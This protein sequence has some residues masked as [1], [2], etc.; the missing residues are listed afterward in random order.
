M[1]TRLLAWWD[2]IRSSYW[3]IPTGMAVGASILAWLVLFLEPSET[4]DFLRRVPWFYANQPAGARSLLSTIAGSM[5]TVAGVTFTVTIAAVSFTAGQFGP[6]ILT[7][8]MRDRGNQ[9]TLGTFIA[10]F[11]YGLLLLRTVREPGEPVEDPGAEGLAVVAEAFVPHVGIVVALMLAVLSVAVLIYFLHHVPESIHISNV[12]ADIGKELNRRTG[13]IF[14]GRLG[15]APGEDAGED[16]ESFLDSLEGDRVEVRADGEGYVQRLDD[17]RLLRVAEE[18]DLRVHLRYRPGDFVARGRVLM[19]AGPAERVDERMERRLRSTFVLG[20]TRTPSQDVLFL[21]EELVEIAVRALST[22]VND[23]FTTVLCLDWLGAAITSMATD[24]TPTSLR[25]DSQ[26]APRVLAEPERFEDLVDLTFRDTRQYV[27]GDRNAC[28]HALKVLA[29][30]ALDL[31]DEEKRA[32][33]L[34]AGEELISEARRRLEPE[35]LEE[36]EG[37][38]VVVRDLLS[39]R[40]DDVHPGGIRWVR[41]SR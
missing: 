19:V 3:F 8:F 2:R 11:L 10:T 20:R 28:L 41:G 35:S 22:G 1:H 33:L 14:P 17:D 15:R 23:P 24:E 12:V 7:N 36:I 5:I 37:R 34:D 29:E 39:G 27:A 18:E 30:L 13:E 16:T 32:Y 6:R 31:E 9:I 40:S 38:L 4:P 26:G 21:A 25:A